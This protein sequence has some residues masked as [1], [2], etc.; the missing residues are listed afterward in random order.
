MIWNVYIRLTPLTKADMCQQQEET[1][2]EMFKTMCKT[3]MVSPAKIQ[4]SH[5]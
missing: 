3:F 4:M 1:E 5:Q 2:G